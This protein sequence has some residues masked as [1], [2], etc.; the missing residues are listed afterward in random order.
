VDLTT[1]QFSWPAFPLLGVVLTQKRMC[2]FTDDGTP[3]HCGLTHS[4]QTFGNSGQ[5]IRVAYPPLPWFLPG[6]ICIRGGLARHFASAWLFHRGIHF[7]ASL[8]WLEIKVTHYQSVGPRNRWPKGGFYY[9]S[10]ESTLAR[11]QPV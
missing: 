8:A 11:I 3:L 1:Y 9:F 6:A 2:H 4:R 10:Q 5:Y 7:E